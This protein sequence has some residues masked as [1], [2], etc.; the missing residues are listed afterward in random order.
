MMEL[1]VSNRTIIRIVLIVA[2]SVLA[3]RVIAYLHEP[4]IWI[5]T[6]FFLALALEPAVNGLSRYLPR[7]SRGLAVL[8]VL[9]AVVAVV[10]VI[11]VALGPP[12]ATQLYHLGTNLPHAYRDF[13]TSNVAVA[14]FL[15]QHISTS[16]AADALQH[17]SNQILSFGG[18]AVGVVR[19]VFGGIIALTTILLL[20]FFMVLEG[21]RWATLIWSHVPTDK[22]SV[23]EPLLRQMH[24]T[25]YGYVNGNL[26]TS[27]IA[28]VTFG[29]LLLILRVPYAIVLGLLVGV[30]DLIPL[31]GA[32][33]AAILVVAAVLLYNGPTTAL[34]VAAVFIVYQLLENHFLQPIVYSKTLEVSPLIVILALILGA[35]LAGFIGALV[36]IPIAASA[37]ILLKHYLGVRPERSKE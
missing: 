5:L 22:R 12:L 25:V 9:V 26:L 30:I 24:G 32:T 33:V 14:K 2:A 29:V 6:A 16:N 7:R 13:S 34:I 27:L 35:S 23:Y 37:Q 8:L 3:L 10:A 18:S 19:G 28:A 4:L 31:I 21:P 11:L 15:E 17:F 20:T 36:A 1:T